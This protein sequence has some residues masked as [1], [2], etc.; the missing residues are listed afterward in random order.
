MTHK[1]IFTEIYEKDMWGGGSGGGST[2]E[3]TVAY[4]LILQGFL[5]KY[6]IKTVVDFG[7]GDWAF[8]Q[9]IDWTGINYTGVDCVESVIRKNIEK[10]RGDNINFSYMTPG[11]G[12]LLIVKDVLQHWE[13]DDDI[14]QFLS[15]MMLRFKYILITNTPDC[16]T[17]PG[18]FGTRP[19]SAT[20]KPLLFFTPKILAT[21][22][23]SET[24]EVSL[25]Q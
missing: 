22:I 18:P 23:T 9:L 14:T 3:N 4:R 16:Q 15:A 11:F 24:K 17:H 19:L 8:S 7:C 13:N 21:I 2:P 25:I 5:Y 20:K 1:E 10:F 12:D 6:K